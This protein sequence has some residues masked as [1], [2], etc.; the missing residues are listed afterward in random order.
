MSSGADCRQRAEVIS[1]ADACPFIDGN[2]ARLRSCLGF[3]PRSQSF[4]LCTFVHSAQSARYPNFAML[5]PSA[6]PLVKYVI[7]DC[8]FSCA[9]DCS[10]NHS[11]M[12]STV[13]CNSS[14]NN[15][16][17]FCQ[18]SFQ[19][20]CIFVVDCFNFVCAKT[21]I[22]TFFL[23]VVILSCQFVFLTFLANYFVTY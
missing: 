20:C 3:A 13:A 7:N 5:H 11:L 22:F 14:W 8:S 15:F 6:N 18:V 1:S 21:A 16:T 23:V 12:F 17:C 19:L 10:N 9:F 2:Q 4:A